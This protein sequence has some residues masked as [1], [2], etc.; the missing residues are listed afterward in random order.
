[1]AALSGCLSL[2]MCKRV[3][4]TFLQVCYT[5]VMPS[6]FI[7][8]DNQGELGGGWEI[9]RLAQLKRKYIENSSFQ[10]LKFKKSMKCCF[11]LFS[12][13]LISITLLKFEKDI[14]VKNSFHVERIPHL[15]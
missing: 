5:A 6:S 7:L 3:D 4:G 1:M 14:S 15:A 13:Y 11:L 9:Y 12:P 2:G 8:P 10:D